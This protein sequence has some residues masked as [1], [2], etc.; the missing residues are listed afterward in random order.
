MVI[1]TYYLQYYPRMCRSNNILVT[2]QCSLLMLLRRYTTKTVA[3]Q[4]YFI[5]L[6][7]NLGKY[8]VIFNFFQQT[9]VDV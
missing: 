3:V 4:M 8:I 1:G 2:V 7:N 5:S 9:A 6:S